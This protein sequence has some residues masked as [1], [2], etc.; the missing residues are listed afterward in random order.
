MDVVIELASYAELHLLEEKLRSL[1]F[2]NDASSG[3]ICRYRF[4]GIT[5]DIMPVSP[6]ILGFSN[7]WYPEGFALAET[8]VLED[9]PVKLFT[10]PYFLASKLEAFKSRGELD[11]RYSSDFEDIVYVLENNPDWPQ[12][13]HNLQGGI[14]TYLQ[15]TLKGLL[16]NPDFEEGLYAHL[17][18]SS[19]QEKLAEILAGLNSF[20]ALG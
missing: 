5:V 10:L 13:L 3:V 11:F 9:V 15:Q 6:D 19:A 1:G 16:Q 18:R 17:E 8:I 12:Q 20:V 2:A 4:S 7:Q 14:R